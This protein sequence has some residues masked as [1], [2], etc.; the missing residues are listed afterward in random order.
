MKQSALIQELISKTES[1]LAFAQSLTDLETDLLKKSPSNGGWNVLQ[2][3]EHM[4]RYDRFYMDV[5]N[6]KIEQARK[7]KEEKEFKPG[8]MGKLFTQMMLPKKNMLKMKTFPDKDPKVAEV[9]KSVL[10]VFIEQQKAWI[11]VLEKAKQVDLNKNRCKLTLPLL[12]LNLGSAMKFDIY[13][14]E[15]HIAQAKKCLKE[16][17]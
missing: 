12:R 13:H 9:D 17:S 16:H 15:R 11:S 14:N 5:A 3:L 7:T 10:H 4:N 8:W 6:Q 2:C 1:H